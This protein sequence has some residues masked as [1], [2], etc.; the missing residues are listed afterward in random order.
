M[1]IVVQGK[2]WRIVPLKGK[3]KKRYKKTNVKP[4]KVELKRKVGKKK[5]VIW[6]RNEK[7]GPPSCVKTKESK[8]KEELFWRAWIGMGC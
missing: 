6:P 4:K 7:D 3:W 1:V 2:V 5:G 8:E